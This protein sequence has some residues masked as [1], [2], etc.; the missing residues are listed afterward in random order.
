MLGERTLNSAPASWAHNTPKRAVAAAS[1][2]AAERP[3]LCAGFARSSEDDNMDPLKV[4]TVQI[5]CRTRLNP[6]GHTRNAS[7]RARLA[8]AARDV[9]KR[10]AAR[11]FRHG[12]RGLQTRGHLA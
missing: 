1:A 3:R 6:S 10:L 12:A 8:H 5:T 11:R 9:A 4:A 7:D 2:M